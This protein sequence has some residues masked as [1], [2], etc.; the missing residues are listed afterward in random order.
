[1]ELEH[2]GESRDFR[3]MPAYLVKSFVEPISYYGLWP[4]KEGDHRDLIKSL[5]KIFG[6]FF[7]SPPPS[8]PDLGT[9][10]GRV[11]HGELRSVLERH[12]RT[13]KLNL[14]NQNP[15]PV[16]WSLRAILEG[17]LSY[18]LDRRRADLQRR[19]AQIQYPKDRKR[20]EAILQAL[21]AD[22]ELDDIIFLGETTDTLPTHAIILCRLIQRFGNFVHPWKQTKYLGKLELDTTRAILLESSCRLVLQ[23][24][25]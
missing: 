2:R 11:S 5:G 9:L 15:D 10:V 19:I 7:D 18:D 13:A 20:L 14:E 23:K 6:R 24:L 1:M 12:C 25:L 17:C 21:P 8:L 4:K 16:A 22:S 3:L